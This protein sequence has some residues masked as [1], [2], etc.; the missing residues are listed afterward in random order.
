MPFN[1]TL[2]IFCKNKQLILICYKTGKYKE[3]GNPK[4][5]IYFIQ[6]V[7]Q[8]RFFHSCYFLK[9]SM[10]FNFV[11]SPLVFASCGQFVLFAISFR[12]TFTVMRT[13]HCYQTSSI[14]K[15]HRAKP[16]ASWTFQGTGIFA[17]CSWFL[18]MTPIYN[19]TSLAVDFVIS[20]VH[21]WS[22][23]CLFLKATIAVLD[24]MAFRFTIDTYRRAVVIAIINF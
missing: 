4:N 11:L 21:L 6:K 20:T 1:Y 18:G 5:L 17:N 15:S 8:S 7:F 24:T 22:L 13:W 12:W 3:K 16:L 2:K 9:L 23:A 14:V 10:F 19:F